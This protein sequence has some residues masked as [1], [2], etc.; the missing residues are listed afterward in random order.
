MIYHIID[1]IYLSDLNSAHNLTLL[2]INNI[3]IIIRLSESDNN[4]IY[5]SNID[6]YNFV[7]EDNMLFS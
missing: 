7:L 1:N 5:D 3:Q 2:I 6:F 4:S